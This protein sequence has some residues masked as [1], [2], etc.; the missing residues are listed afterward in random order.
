MGVALVALFVALSGTSYAVSRVALPENS[1]GTTQLRNDSV[2]RAKIAHESITSVLIKDGSLLVQ[3]FKAGQLPA[4]PAG[5]VGPAGLAG[6]QG[7][8]GDRGDT[9]ETG[10]TGPSG[11]KGE[12]GDPGEMGPIVVQSDSAQVSK[13]GTETVTA[14][15]GDGLRAVS[16]GMSWSEAAPSLSTVYLRPVVDGFGVVSGFTAQG[17]NGDT[18]SHEFSVQA[19]CIV[20]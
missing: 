19:L 20:D 12:K 15:C 11:E 5:P 13:G 8:K 14:L 3:D 10:A 4:G 7:P 9:G 2:T 18:H 1:V 17:Y 16:A 6:P